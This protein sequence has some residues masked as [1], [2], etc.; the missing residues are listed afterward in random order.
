[1]H[2]L[3]TSS[4][5]QS[6]GDGADVSVPVGAGGL[7]PGA[8]LPPPA[9]PLWSGSTPAQYGGGRGGTAAAAAVG[10]QRRPHKPLPYHARRTGLQDGGYLP[11]G[12]AQS[13]ERR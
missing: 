9:P 10:P 6:D 4:P 8:L 7:Q 12:C 3:L 5:P 13:Q 1:M 11:D 2:L